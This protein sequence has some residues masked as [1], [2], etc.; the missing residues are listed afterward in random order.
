[1]SFLFGE[2]ER[3]LL[4]AHRSVNALNRHLTRNFSSR[5][6]PDMGEL[7]WRF[8][9]SRGIMFGCKSTD[10]NRARGRTIV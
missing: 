10:Q 2:K 4:D 9:W 3:L 5:D 8:V 7:K 6:I 1:M